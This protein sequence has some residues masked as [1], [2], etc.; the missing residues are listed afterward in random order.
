MT[1]PANQIVPPLQT[2]PLSRMRLRRNIRVDLIGKIGL[3]SAWPSAVNE[4]SSTS[5]DASVR[6]TCVKPQSASVFSVPLYV[7]VQFITLNRRDAKT[8]REEKGA[9]L[10]WFQAPL[11]SAP[12]C[13]CASAVH[14]LSFN[15][16]F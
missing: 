4:S 16:D 8:Q 5:C 2:P 9:F 15:A 13:L 11:G 12:L 6:E 7:I 10:H 1:I 14:L 3:P